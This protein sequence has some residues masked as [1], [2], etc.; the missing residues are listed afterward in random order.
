M[1]NKPSES[2]AN[3]GKKEEKK[4][5]LNPIRIKKREINEDTDIDTDTKVL[6]SDLMQSSKIISTKFPIEERSMQKKL[7]VIIFDNF[8]Y[9]SLRQ[10][11]LGNR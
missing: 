7:T 6:Q 1:N 2:I 4:V 8:T 11:L 3:K 10:L 9:I 5:I